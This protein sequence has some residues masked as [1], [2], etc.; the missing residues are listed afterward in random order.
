MSRS[1]Y[2]TSTFLEN[3][4]SGSRAL[5][6]CE[7]F[8]VVTSSCINAFL[9]SLSLILL[10]HVIDLCV[11]SP[12]ILE[13]IYLILIDLCQPHECSSAAVT[14]HSYFSCIR[15]VVILSIQQT[16][17]ILPFNDQIRFGFVTIAV[18]LMFSTSL[19]LDVTLHE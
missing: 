17:N 1:I 8:Q 2:P 5:S 14:R 3:E 9:L 18:S 6:H 19:L 4:P 13:S 12:S 15:D 11:H 16:P 10:A 7:V